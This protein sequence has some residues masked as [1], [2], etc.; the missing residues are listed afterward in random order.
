[1]GYAQVIE[2][3]D[4]WYWVE[5]QNA[6]GFVGIDRE[7]RFVQGSAIWLEFFQAWQFDDLIET[8]S[9]GPTCKVKRIKT[10]DIDHLHSC[11][12]CRSDFP[13]YD[14]STAKHPCTRRKCDV[15]TERFSK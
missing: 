1:M 15:C 6:S 4:R 5:T 8:L 9:L 11:R 3:G 14:L 10:A 2:P 13:C 12:I 7:G